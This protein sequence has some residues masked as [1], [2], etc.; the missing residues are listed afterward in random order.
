MATKKKTTKKATKKATTKR[1]LGYCEKK[2][3]VE[4]KKEVKMNLYL[5]TFQQQHL[6]YGVENEIEGTE[7]DPYTGIHKVDGVDV[8]ISIKKITNLKELNKL[9]EELN[10]D[11][12]DGVI[13]TQTALDRFGDEVVDKYNDNFI[14][15]TV[16]DIEKMCD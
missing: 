5:V 6:V 12:F 13:F 14:V 3:Q 16:V 11:S 9:A 15:S 7:L 2:T 10:F 4:P 8:P 1:I